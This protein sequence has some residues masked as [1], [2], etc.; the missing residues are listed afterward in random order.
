MHQLGR[1]KKHG[2]VIVIGWCFLLPSSVY[3]QCYLTA[4]D[5]NIHSATPAEK[6][7]RLGID[8]TS[9]DSVYQVLRQEILTKSMYAALFLAEHGERRALELIK[10]KYREERAYSRAALYYLKALNKLNYGP[11]K[12][13]L[14]AFADS[15]YQIVATGSTDRT[16]NFVYQEA[17]EQ[18]MELGNYSQFPRIRK[19][20][21][22]RLR[23]EEYVPGY[24]SLLLDFLEVDNS[25]R[26]QVIDTFVFILRNNQVSTR[27]SSVVNFS[28]LFPESKELQ[29]AL[30]AAAVEDPSFEVRWWALVRLKNNFQDPSI[31]DLTLANLDR[32]SDLDELEKYVRLI[33]RAY[34]PRSLH[35]IKDFKDNSPHAAVRQEAAKIYEDYWSLYFEPYGEEFDYSVGQTLDSLRV[36]T[37]DVASYDWLGDRGFVRELTNR[38]QTAARHL[39]RG[40][41]AGAAKQISTYQQRLRQVAKQPPQGRSP[42]FV[43]EDGYKFLT[44]NAQYLLSRLPG[45]PSDNK[46]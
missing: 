20:L 15:M 31:L 2:W 12:G 19:V 45:H 11:A 24:M 28:C 46:R 35:L 42:R 43:T 44:K 27:R 7:H 29:Q 36:Y 18:L 10:E 6:L 41:S 22:S 17:V 9:T 13:M 23:E 38:L 30:K 32:T 26:Q 4:S 37:E 25:L 34:T 21:Q 3:S 40:D 5:I 8:T 14:V 16:E 1:Y 39:A 33:S